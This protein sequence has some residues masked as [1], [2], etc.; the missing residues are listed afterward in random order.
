MHQSC[1]L[2]FETVKS[3]SRSRDSSLELL[4]LAS[5]KDNTI[6][7]LLHLTMMHEPADGGFFERQAVLFLGR[8]LRHASLVSALVVIK[9]RTATILTSFSASTACVYRSANRQAT[10]LLGWKR[11]LARVS[12]FWRVTPAK[13]PPLYEG[14]HYSLTTHEPFDTKLTQ[15]ESRLRT[16]SR[17]SANKGTTCKPLPVSILYRIVLVTR[18]YERL[19]RVRSASQSSYITPDKR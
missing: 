16:G 3:D 12:S 9:V 15:Q 17:I 5:T 13:K 10:G 6:I 18:E 7:G 19:T 11:L 14:Q 8:F 2:A 4:Y 1:V